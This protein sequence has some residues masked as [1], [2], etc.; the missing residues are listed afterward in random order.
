MKGYLDMNRLMLIMYI[1]I[2]IIVSYMLIPVAYAAPDDEGAMPDDDLIQ[3][4]LDNLDIS[5]IAKFYENFASEDYPDIGTLLKDMLRGRIPFD[6][7]Q[8]IKNLVSGLFKEVWQNI[9]LI[10]N[11]LIIAIAAGILN[12]LQSSFD[13]KSAGEMAFYACYILIIMVIIQSFSQMMNYGQ[14]ALSN[15]VLFMQAFAPTMYTLL[16]ASG[17]VSSSVMFQPLMALLVGVVG[18]FVKDVVLPLLFLSAILTLVNHISDKAPLGKLAD[19]LKNI[20][21]W[22]LK[23]TFI[24]FSAIVIIQ[25]ITAG[26]FDSVSFRTAKFA[27]DN[28]V[29]VVG[30]ALSDSMATVVSYSALVKSAIG[31]IGLII[32][33]SICLFPAIKIAAVALVYKFAAALIEPI[34]QPRI[35]Q[36]LN[37]I[38]DIL[39]MLFTLVFSVAVMF[40][41][42][43]AML[44]G[45]NSP[46]AI[47]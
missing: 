24:I 35:C 41:I 42:A 12:Q 28:F 31:V 17:A 37:S 34:A 3:Q 11:V 39:I 25:G 13:S 38:G 30:R 36:C 4:Q 44:I 5:E 10:S 19:L 23:L 33:A 29:P 26:S 8:I 47:L 43:I 32:L 1:S 14:E 22:A 46:Q 16:V 2:I 18:T 15:M 40:F 20:C 45:I 21:S 9:G 27:V 6:V 7:W